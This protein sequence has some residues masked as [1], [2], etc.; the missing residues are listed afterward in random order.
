MRTGDTALRGVRRSLIWPLVALLDVQV[1]QQ[2]DEYQ[3][4]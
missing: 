2:V 3:P 1:G 4:R